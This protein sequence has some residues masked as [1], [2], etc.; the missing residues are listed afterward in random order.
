MLCHV[1]AEAILA[2]DEHDV[3]EAIVAI[4]ADIRDGNIGFRLGELVKD[5]VQLRDTSLVT[6]K[7]VIGLLADAEVRDVLFQKVDKLHRFSP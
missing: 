2:F 4:D 3:A 6:A 5:G 7:D 1:V